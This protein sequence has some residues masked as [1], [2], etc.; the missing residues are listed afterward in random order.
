MKNK[1]NNWAVGKAL[2]PRRAFTLIEL[3]VVIAIIAILAAMLLPA[4]T[5]AKAKAQGINCMNNL[6]QLQLCWIMFSGDNND[7]M[8]PNIVA[9]GA[10][11]W[12]DGNM[13]NYP[14]FTNTINIQNGLL[15]N[16]SKN[17][18]VY[19][20]PYA[21]AVTIGGLTAIAV[22]HYSIT[23]RMGG[24]NTAVLPAYPNYT[25]TTQ[26][27]NPG[28]SDALVFVEES[29]NT[30][31]DGYFAVPD[32]WTWQNSPTIRHA[33]GGNFSFVDG[34]AEPHR[35][36]TLNSEQ[37]FNIAGNPATAANVDLQWIH[38]AVFRP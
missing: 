36:R 33:L 10:G 32:S 7:G 18:A 28:P 35:W 23:G 22:R 27:R 15:Y 37:S 4:L 8:V 34:H 16:Y 13:Q 17:A 29:A 11:S 12:V 20:C 25:K 21:K 3:L 19:R 38:N 30:I 2:L 24:D 14:S 26:V 6:K 9:G 1:T 5:K 31:D